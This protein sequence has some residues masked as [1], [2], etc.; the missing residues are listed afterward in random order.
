MQVAELGIVWVTGPGWR[1]RLSEDGVD[2]YHISMDEVF[3]IV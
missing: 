3:R 2:T 1:G